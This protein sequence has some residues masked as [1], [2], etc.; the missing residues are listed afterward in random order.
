[1]NATLTR[2]TIHAAFAALER[3]ADENGLE[4]CSLFRKAFDAARDGERAHRRMGRGLGGYRQS[5]D[6]AAR[7]FVVKWFL[8]PAKITDARSAAAVRLDCLYAS[9]LRAEL[10]GR[11]GADFADLRAKLEPVASIDYTTHIVRDA[12]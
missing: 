2:S 7:Y 5:A 10:I 11:M 9:A 3:A 4:A 8:D 12:A 6:T 1:M